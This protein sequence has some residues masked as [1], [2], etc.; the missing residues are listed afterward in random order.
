MIV[1]WTVSWRRNMS[2]ISLTSIDVAI[3]FMEGCGRWEDLK[4]RNAIV[5][6]FGFF[7]SPLFYKTEKKKT[8]ARVTNFWLMWLVV[9]LSGNTKLVQC[10][11]V[12]LCLQ[13]STAG[14]HA[15]SV[16]RAITAST[17]I[18]ILVQD[19]VTKFLRDKEETSIFFFNLSFA[20]RAS[21]EK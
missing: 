6:F 17:I 12:H 3:S 19:F 13:Y 10:K 11:Y 20:R 5:T 7:S 21:S 18:F 8:S 9:I 1:S 15:G 14:N 4:E 16:Y 2:I